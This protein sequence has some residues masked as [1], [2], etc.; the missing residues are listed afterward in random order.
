MLTDAD[1]SMLVERLGSTVGTREEEQ[2]WELLRPLGA[3][4]LPFF[5]DAYPRTRKWQGRVSFIYHALKYARAD[6]LASKLAKVAL[7]DKSRLVRYRACMLIACALDRSALPLLGQ[8]SAHPDAAT[9][10]DARAAID[11]IEHSNHHYFVDR[12]HSGRVELNFDGRPLH[13]EPTR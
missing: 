12:H 6:P 4:V 2:V 10:E 1:I 11:A 7:W 3:K 5:L 13:E 9:V 8:L